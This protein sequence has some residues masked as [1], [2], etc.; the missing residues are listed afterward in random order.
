VLR[1]LRSAEAL[2]SAIRYIQPGYPN[3]IRSIALGI[4]GQAGEK[5]SLSR[6]LVFRL[7]GDFS[8]TIRN[9]VV[10]TLMIWGDEECRTLLA[11]RKEL[12]TDPE[13]LKAIDT[14]LG[15]SEKNSSP[16]K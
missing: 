2:P 10:K 16:I 3:D 15:H 14:A 7:A 9:G 6:A 12:E 13:V 4:L 5:D 11:R 8:P 1:S